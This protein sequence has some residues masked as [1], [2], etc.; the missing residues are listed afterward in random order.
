MTLVV[1][2]PLIAALAA[3]VLAWQHA[4]RL[5]RESL[6]SGWRGEP[7]DGGGWMLVLGA[8]VAAVAAT[9]ALQFVLL[10]QLPSSNG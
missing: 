8:L 1:L 9:T 3:G 2:G 10:S 4:T 5:D 6:R 7:A